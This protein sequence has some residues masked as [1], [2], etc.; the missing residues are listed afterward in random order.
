M[1]FFLAIFVPI[2]LVIYLLITD[3]CDLFPYNDVSQHTSSVRKGELINYILPL[4]SALCSWYQLNLV[5]F[6]IALLFL[7]GNMYFWWIPYFFGC[8]PQRK[9]I[10]EKH[11]GRTIKILPPIKDHPIPNLE[12]MPVALLI[13]VWLIATASLLTTLP[14]HSTE[15]RGSVLSYGQGNVQV[16]VQIDEYK[17]IVAGQPIEGTIMI[18]HEEKNKIDESSFRMGDKPL[19]VI[20]VKESSMA[21]GPLMVSIYKFSVEGQK[22]GLQNLPPISVK[23]DGKEYTTPPTSILVN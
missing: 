5:P 8:S 15:E 3:F 11:F 18:T 22:Q 21:S 7:F 1:M 9:E 20:P 16:D 12:H 10:M 4:I 14:L 6:V 19:R 17:P 13:L 23:I 2:V